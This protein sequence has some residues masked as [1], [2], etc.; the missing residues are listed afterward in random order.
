MTEQEEYSLGCSSIFK[1]METQ[2]TLNKVIK[3]M[4]TI[5]HALG[6][7]LGKKSKEKLKW[8]VYGLKEEVIE[9]RNKL[10]V[11]KID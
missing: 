8:Y 1:E 3:S 5:V 11:L 7:P 10:Q 2:K 6:Y 9:L 4:E